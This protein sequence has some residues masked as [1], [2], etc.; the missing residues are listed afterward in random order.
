[1]CPAMCVRAKARPSK[2]VK[3]EKSDAK[4]KYHCTTPHQMQ[5]TL[6][7][8]FARK[9]EVEKLL[10]E[11]KTID[12]GKG[13][14]VKIE[15]DVDNDNVN[16]EE[17]QPVPTVIKNKANVKLEWYSRKKPVLVEGSVAQTPR[18]PFFRMQ[19]KFKPDRAPKPPLKGSVAMS[20]VHTKFEPDRANDDRLEPTEFKQHVAQHGDDRLEPPQPLTKPKRVAISMEHTKVEPDRS[21]DDRLEPTIGRAHDDWVHKESKRK[22]YGTTKSGWFWNWYTNRWEWYEQEGYWRWNWKGWFK[23]RPKTWTFKQWQQRHSTS[24]R[25]RN[26]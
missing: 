10:L 6:Q 18:K 23:K 2:T 14:N 22:W 19:A 12:K 8:A 20:M 26:F 5:T 3:T 7:K 25:K 11:Q 24:R 21:N 17:A 4:G 13:T 15:Q 1:M 9:R 16:V